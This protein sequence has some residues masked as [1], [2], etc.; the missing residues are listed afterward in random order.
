MTAP[1]LDDVAEQ[2]IEAMPEAPLAA[3]ATAATV[4]VSLDDIYETIREMSR[5]KDAQSMVRH[6]ADRMKA[7]YPDQHRVSLSRRGL[8]FP[9]FR[10][11]RTSKW[12]EEGRYVDPWQNPEETVVRSGGL[13]AELIYKGRPKVIDEIELDPS[14]P[15]SEFFADCRS[16][17]AIPLLDDGEAL[18]MVVLGRGVSHGF[19][20]SRVPERFWVSNLFG[21]A[22]QAL[23][24]S[25]ELRTAYDAADREMRTIAGIQ[26]GL[27]PQEVPDVPGLSL[28]A[29]Y[30]TSA[31]AGGDYYD[32]FELPDGR[33]GLLIA[34][35]SG[36]G[37]AA[38][39]VMAITRSI[40]HLFPC[41]S[42]DPGDLLAFCNQQ[43]ATQYTNHFEAF[44]TAFYAIFDPATKTLKYA[45]AGHNPPRVW[46]CRQRRCIELDEGGNLPLGL[47]PDLE[48]PLATVSLEQGDRLVM[49]TD[50]IVEAAS[51]DGSL[52]GTTRLDLLLGGA[53]HLH[54]QGTVD[55]IIAAVNGFTHGAGAEDDRTMIVAMVE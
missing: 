41:Q 55:A 28:A 46:K 47:L 26:R 52:F 14:D 5:Q 15:A 8:Q 31:R 23:V 6:Y 30:E 34:D 13:L 54:P 12:E 45:T 36:H 18:N 51:P 33:W 44:V 40:A 19:D 32:F 29:Y 2:Q 20:P 16:L 48:Y 21:R 3:D 37:A 4:G 25:Q 49:Y 10:I 42:P 7:I 11:T 9:E 17:L 35:V 1:Q 39:V 22:T 24:L 27:L 38:A 43:L 50:G 53:C